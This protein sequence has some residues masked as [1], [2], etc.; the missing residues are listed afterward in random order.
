MT[1]DVGEVSL[2]LTPTPHHH[3]PEP[4]MAMAYC[5]SHL[6]P[7]VAR[8]LTAAA[9]ASKSLTPL[10]QV[11]EVQGYDGVQ[12]KRVQ[13]IFDETKKAAGKKKTVEV[14]PTTKRK[15]KLKVARVFFFA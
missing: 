11:I 10:P 6:T 14:S 8:G 3:N 1:K 4:V 2:S 15:Q 12:Q 13:Q 7:A 5:C 9:A